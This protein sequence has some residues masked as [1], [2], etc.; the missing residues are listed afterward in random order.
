[1]VP[2]SDRLAPYLEYF[3]TRYLP[4]H[5]D[6]SAHTLA[7]YKQ[8]FVQLLRYHQSR[9]PEETDPLLARFQVPF[10]LEF[11]VW[12]EKHRHNCPS[13]RN[14]RLAALKSF[15]RML[16][17]LR[18]ES[19]VQCQQVLLIPAKRT[20]A[21]PLDYLDKTEVD[22]LFRAVDPSAPEGYRDLCLLRLLYNTGARAS[23]VCALR[24]ND[25]ELEARWVRLCGK[26]R[27]L[28]TVPLWETTLAF[29]KIYLKSERRRP[30]A[31]Y[32][33]F[34]FIN[35]R[36]ARLTRSGLYTLCRHYLE[37]A[38]QGLPS[39]RHKQLHPVHLWRYTT[40][41]HLLLAGVDP[42]VIQDWLGHT[43]IN[44]TARYKKVPVDVKREALRKF[45]LFEK[46]WQE[47]IFGSDQTLSPSLL[48]F[49]EAL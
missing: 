26:G 6:V 32:Q 3:F 36:G 38:R 42:T 46:S 20:A 23:E 27:R 10:L 24:V 13:T 4:G 41:T 37:R 19:A 21:R 22:A 34:L 35:Q 28:R 29:L 15:F 8:T 40:A 47:P 30:Q 9:F 17:L 16:A 33:E 12:L 14:T 11:L 43:S 7:G 18:P 39:L 2:H 44:S 1:M 48:A 31:A 5:Q 49:L 45:Y 25:L